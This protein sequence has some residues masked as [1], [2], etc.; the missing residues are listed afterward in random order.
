MS[1][2]KGMTVHLDAET[3]AALEEQRVK[4]AEQ[5]PDYALPFCTLPMLARQ[6]VK[7]WCEAQAASAEQEGR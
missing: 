1:D 4:L 7:G 2:K 5:L 3:V 6:A